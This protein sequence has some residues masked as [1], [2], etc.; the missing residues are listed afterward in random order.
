[1][2]YKFETLQV[3]AGYSPEAGTGARAVPIYQTTAYQF[4]NASDAAAQFAL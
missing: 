1:M 3:H 2:E 4:E